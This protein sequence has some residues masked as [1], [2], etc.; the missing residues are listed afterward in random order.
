MTTRIDPPAPRTQGQGG[1]PLVPECLPHLAG[2]TVVL[3][4]SGGRDSVALLLLL[5]RLGCALL[6]CHVHHGI[7]GAAAD[8]D[9]AW[10]AALC[11][12]LGVP[13]EEHRVSVPQ[14]AAESGE[15]LETAARRARHSLLQ[16]A[17]ARCGGNT[18]ALAHHADDQAETVLF[19]LA[20]GAAGC[21]GMQ[22]VRQDAATTWLRPL[23]QLTRAGITA[24][25]TDQ[26]QDWRDDATNAVPDV[27]RNALRLQVI[28]ALNRAMGRDVSPILNRSARLQQDTLDALET[29]LSLL[30]LTDPQGRLYLPALAGRPAA[31]CRAVLHRYLKRAGVPDLSARHVAAAES[32]ISPAAAQSRI[33]LPGGFTA[34]RKEK[35]LCLSCGGA[36]IPVPWVDAP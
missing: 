13:F 27:A 15:S 18:V 16:A 4:L 32:I 31:F 10:C 28:P 8:E 22:P 11:A 29:A 23:L 20:R 24:W 21:R 6:A 26:G 5:H 2:R 7:R 33:T 12:R 36:L 17:A 30:P 25:L 14:L 3:G 35:R 1:L 19:R 9:A 34:F